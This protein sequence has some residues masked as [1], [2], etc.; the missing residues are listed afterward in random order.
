MLSTGT[1]GNKTIQQEAN[2]A[3]SIA[4]YRGKGVLLYLSG[5][6]IRNQL[7]SNKIFCLFQSFPP[8][9]R[10][11]VSQVKQCLQVLHFD[12]RISTN[13]TFDSIDSTLYSVDQWAY[14]SH[15]CEVLLDR[16]NQFFVQH[17]FASYHHFTSYPLFSISCRTSTLLHSSIRRQLEYINPVNKFW[18]IGMMYSFWLF[19]HSFLPV[20]YQSPVVP[21]YTGLV[22]RLCT[23]DFHY[24]GLLGTEPVILKVQTSIVPPTTDASGYFSI[25]CF[26]QFQ[27]MLCSGPLPYIQN[28]WRTLTGHVV[29]S[30]YS[31]SRCTRVISFK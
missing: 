28:D 15:D 2:Q 20:G 3:P 18:V 12:T 22:S 25:P 13:Y 8:E 6:Q 9:T 21:Q 7:S 14:C 11:S 16:A 23:S 26:E 19:L 10:R 17:I 27:G 29:T 1:G 31:D 30:R 4:R 24:R 5:D